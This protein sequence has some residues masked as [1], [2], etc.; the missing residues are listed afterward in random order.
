VVTG[1]HAQR[2]FR[3]VYQYGA[4]DL[5]EAVNSAF[6]NLSSNSPSLDIE[7]HTR[8]DLRQQVFSVVQFVVVLTHNSTLL[9]LALSNSSKYVAKRRK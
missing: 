5:G 2:S 1:R 8:S 7:R 3:V 9:K 4:I 6:V